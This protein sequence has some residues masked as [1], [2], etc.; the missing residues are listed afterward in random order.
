MNETDT[1]ADLENAFVAAI[2]EDFTYWSARN[3]TMFEKLAYVMYPS[4]FGTIV[5]DAEK[6]MYD[7]QH[8]AMNAAQIEANETYIP[9]TV[10][11]RTYETETKYIEEEISLIEPKHCEHLHGIDT[12]NVVCFQCSK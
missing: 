10:C 5:H 7:T 9:V 8:D 4:Y 3:K 12:S 1:L 11:K 2:K 6:Q